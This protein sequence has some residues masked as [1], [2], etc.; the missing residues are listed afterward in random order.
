MRHE[1]V[2]EHQYEL[3]NRME[4]LKK[5]KHLAKFIQMFRIAKNC[6]SSLT[7]YFSEKKEVAFRVWLVKP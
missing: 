6:Q 4:L 2:V 5:Q 1:Q 7:V 3:Q